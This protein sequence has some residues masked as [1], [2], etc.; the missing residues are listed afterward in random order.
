MVKA[1]HVLE[2]LAKL[3]EVLLAKVNDHVVNFYVDHALNVLVVIRSEE[4]TA[5]EEVMRRP[6]HTLLC[7]CL[8]LGGPLSI[9]DAVTLAVACHH[10]H[11]L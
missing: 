1:A 11:R 6:E 10:H 7:V 4:E 5:A 8:A 2:S 3:G 9:P